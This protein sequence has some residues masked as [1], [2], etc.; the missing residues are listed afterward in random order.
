MRRI[1]ALFLMSLAVFLLLMGTAGCIFGG[2]YVRLRGTNEIHDPDCPK[3]R[4]AH[5]D[6][7]VDAD[8][9]DGPPCYTCLPEEAV[10]WAEDQD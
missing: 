10:E 7:V 8:L 3:V 6:G 1:V 5:P 9:D 4:R 2:S